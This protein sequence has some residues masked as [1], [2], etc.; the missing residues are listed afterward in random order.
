[1]K[2]TIAL[3]LIAL[4]IC[5]FSVVALQ[6]KSFGSK[7]LSSKFLSGFKL[8]DAD[9]LRAP[10][11][12]PGRLACVQE[13]TPENYWETL[14]SGERPAV[15][16]FYSPI[17]GPCRLMAPFYTELCTAYRG[18]LDFYQLDIFR[19]LDFY[20]SLGL[21]HV[22]ALFFYNEGMEIGRVTEITPDIEFLRAEI[23]GF[24]AGI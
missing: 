1:M 13:L 14:R 3:A 22:P 23:E 24:L 11:I 19:D 10:R 6:Q 8:I 15:V 5:S 9:K 2:K 16:K 7:T 21:N 17:C 4:F 20:F 12:S 18:R